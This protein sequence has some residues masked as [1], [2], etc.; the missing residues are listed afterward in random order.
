MVS[1]AGSL[2][3]FGSSFVQWWYGSWLTEIITGLAGALIGVFLWANAKSPKL[4]YSGAL[5]A[6]LAGMHAVLQPYLPALLSLAYLGVFV[7]TAIVWDS[8]RSGALASQGKHRAWA[9][10]LGVAAFAGLFW[11]YY[12][13]AK[14]AIE[15]VLNTVYPGKRTLAG[16]GLP[17]SD[18]GVGFF[19][20]WRDKYQTP[21][22]LNSSEAARP[23]LV[24]PFVALAAI[25]M[26]RRVQLGATFWAILAYCAFA[27][28]WISVPLPDPFGQWFGSIG[29]ERIPNS[30]MYGGLG[31]ASWM[32][33]VVVFAR[34][35]EQQGLK[36]SHTFLLVLGVVATV[37][38]AWSFY[39]LQSPLYFTV[40]RLFVAMLVLSSVVWAVCRSNRIVFFAG[41]LLA[42]YMPVQ[43]NPTS[44]GLNRLLDKELLHRTKAMDPSGQEKWIVFG[45]T[46]LSQVL[47]ANGHQVLSGEYFAPR[48]DL[49]RRLDPNE[50]N[51]YWWN[52]YGTVNFATSTSDLS[53]IEYVKSW[54]S[55]PD[56]FTLHPC[57][58][59]LKALG[60]TRFVFHEKPD[61]SQLP[62]LKP[63]G[64]FTPIS[65]FVYG[66]TSTTP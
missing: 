8:R 53:R 49:M 37:Y 59:T 46:P 14:A 47:R 39:R 30:R 52:R 28:T 51:I 65:V 20:F 15:V 12:E 42:I 2:A 22:P 64:E 29:L 32:L 16:G 5:L 18:F 55:K 1:L 27:V 61:L 35:K 63:L 57:H 50:T 38:W 3:V 36:R 13:S 43:I 66:A 60:V 23:I 21:L 62:C 44:S 26:A 40:E 58:P 6:A 31:V 41:V 34:F 48:F 56:A 33:A 7:G 54:P 24:F 25:A 45:G 17:W 9:I 4:I 10:A 19:D 11:S